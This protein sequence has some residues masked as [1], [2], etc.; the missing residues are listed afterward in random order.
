MVPVGRTPPA[1]RKDLTCSETHVEQEDKPVTLPAKVGEPQG[2]SLVSFPLFFAFQGPPV[3]QPA[4]VSFSST[5]GVCRC[6]QDGP[7]T[8]ILSVYKRKNAPTDVGNP[9]P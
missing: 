3:M 7:L 1:N 2:T 6:K 5:N 4:S 8:S 9:E